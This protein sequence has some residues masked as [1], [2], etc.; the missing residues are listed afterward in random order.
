MT[1]SCFSYALRRFLKSHASGS[2]TRGGKSPP[3]FVTCFFARFVSLSAHYGPHASSCRSV[4]GLP[5]T[6]RFSLIGPFHAGRV[7]QQSLTSLYSALVPLT[8]HFLGGRPTSV[9]AVE[10]RSK[11]LYRIL[12][13]AATV[14]SW[15]WP[16]RSQLEHGSPRAPQG[17]YN[18]R[19]AYQSSCRA[20]LR[21]V[22]LYCSK[23]HVRTW[24]SF[25]GLVRWFWENLCSN[26]SL[27]RPGHGRGTVAL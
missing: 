24:I 4:F 17:C 10:S 25:S 12:C 9:P 16:S 14:R 5:L 23:P 8:H 1:C 11:S 22:R 7:L 13:C 2:R 27:F 18:H 19:S 20:Q 26:G 21:F 6:L 15:S 3:A